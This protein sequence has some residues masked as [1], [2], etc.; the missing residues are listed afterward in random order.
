[1]NSFDASYSFWSLSLNLILFHTSLFSSPFP[2]TLSTSTRFT[3]LYFNSTVSSLPPLQLGTSLPTHKRSSL[4]PHQRVQPASPP[5]GVQPAS[6]PAGVQP[7]SPAAEVQPASPAAG[8]QPASP[9]A[10]VQPTSPPAGPTYLPTSGSSLPPLRLVSSQRAATPDT[11]PATQVFLAWVAGLWWRVSQHII[12]EVGPTHVLRIVIC[13]N[14]SLLDDA[15]YFSVY[16]FSFTT[17]IPQ[18][19]NTIFKLHY[20]FTITPHLYL[21]TSV[22]CQLCFYYRQADSR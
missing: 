4:P 1:M 2:L 8:I 19:S 15:S 16:F 10:G 21:Y 5:A 20:I 7:A 9:A 12:R 17:S 3:S 18:L 11:W 6:P 13:P 22:Q 14:A